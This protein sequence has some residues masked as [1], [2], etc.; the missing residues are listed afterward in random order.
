MENNSALDYLVEFLKS[1]RYS[2]RLSFLNAFVTLIIK[3][4]T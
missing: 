4:K 1:M 3:L 2:R